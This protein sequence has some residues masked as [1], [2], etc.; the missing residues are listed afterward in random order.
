MRTC[1]ICGVID[2]LHEDPDVCPRRADGTWR[3]DETVNAAWCNDPCAACAIRTDGT[4]CVFCCDKADR[5]RCSKC[6]APWEPC[7]DPG[8]RDRGLHHIIEH[9]VSGCQGIMERY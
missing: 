9:T 5:V 7:S 1:R 4:K 8:H 3:A 6:K 2:A